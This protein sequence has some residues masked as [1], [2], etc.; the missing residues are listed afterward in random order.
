MI[1][2]ACRV[3]GNPDLKLVVSLGE[4][5]LAN[6]L[7]T[8]DQLRL[9]EDTYPLNVVFCSNCTLVQIT[10][11]VPPEKLFR[12]YL[13]FSS[14]SDTV[15]Q[16]AAAIANQLIEMRSLTGEHH[17]VEIASNDGYLLQHYKQRGVRV[18]G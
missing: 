15:V 6:A 12:E 13:Y 14:F 2:T 3:C 16:N 18:L 8:K 1:Q 11:T 4:M 9:P 10:C 17:I 5:P 7:L